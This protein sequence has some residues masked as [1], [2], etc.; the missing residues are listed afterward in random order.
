MNKVSDVI[1]SSVGLEQPE[2][3]KLYD[4]ITKEEIQ[5]TPENREA[6]VVIEERLHKEYGYDLDQMLPEFIVQKGSTLIGPA[7][8]VIFNDSKNKNQDNIFAIIE[9]KR[10]DRSDGIEQLK[11]YLA[12]VESA[13]YGIWFNGDD[14]VYIR[15]LKKAPH[16]KLTYNIP[17]K[18]EPL[19]LPI[20]DSLKPAS[21]LVKAFESCHNHIYVNDGHLKDQVFNEMLKILFIKLMDEKDYTSKVCKFGI[22]EEEFDEIQEGK[23]NAFK[24]RIEKLL[25]L[26]KS[27]HKDIFL[28]D[29][30]INLKLTTLAFVVG[31]LQNYDLSHS[32]RDIKGLAFQKFVY[33]HQRGDRGE[34]FTPDPIIDLAVRMINPN[35]NEVVMDPACGTGGFLVS[36]MKHV[37]R[38]L[39][40]AVPNP[41]DYEKAKTNFALK[42]LIGIDFNPSLVRVSKMRM[43]LEEDGHTG[44]FHSNSLIGIDEI[45]KAAK[46]ASSPNVD[47]GAVQVIL[48]N[49]PFGKKGK[50]TDKTILRSLSL[51]HKWVI[52]SGK[53]VKSEKVLDS[54]VPD[55][56]FIERCLEF[57]AEGGRIGIVL[58]D[59][60]LSGPSL[61]YVRDFILSKAKLVAVVSL[62]YST[63]I[64]HG[65]NVKASIMFLQ[66]LSEKR[67]KELNKNDYDVFM[68]DVQEIGY[69]GNKNGTIKYL[70]NDYGEMLRDKK[71][72]KIVNED[73]SQTLNGWEDFR[74]EHTAWEDVDAL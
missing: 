11:T 4:Y 62:P 40:E 15:R 27:Q 64:P 54:Q 70:M 8:V 45:K 20:K 48:T 26:A 72:R 67:I 39:G 53:Y 34:F 22:T 74:K 59:A 16:W 5:N 37:E 71:G 46:T 61:Q 57:L 17:R 41:V 12:G 68:A 24:K 13:Q 1:E 51:G 10:K 14:I 33:A 32:S 35:M 18:D 3:G 69:E 9:C 7:D 52:K 25:N 56:L 21:E 23:E 30:I 50:V 29:E 2:E 36:S 28:K 6:K 58:P 55:I 19:G 66:K 44:I 63:F 31:Q 49:P 65:A 47:Y 60:I 38:N 73:V 42:K 43:I